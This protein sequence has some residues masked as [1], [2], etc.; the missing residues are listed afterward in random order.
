M[1]PL[2][3][4]EA[5]SLAGESIIFHNDKGK[6]SEVEGMPDPEKK[7]IAPLFNLVC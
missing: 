5:D 6:A 1:A 2:G 7:L 4:K 3:R